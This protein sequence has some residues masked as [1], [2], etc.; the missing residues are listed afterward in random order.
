MRAEIAA[1]FREWHF[2]KSCT[3]GLWV[4]ETQISLHWR[5]TEGRGQGFVFLLLFMCASALP[6]SFL[7]AWASQALNRYFTLHLLGRGSLSSS[8]RLAQ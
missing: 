5:S 4:D 1:Y 3:Q 2:R 7:S 8:Q 6:S